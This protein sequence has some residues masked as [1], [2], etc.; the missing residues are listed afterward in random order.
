[1]KKFI[2]AL[3]VMALLVSCAADEKTR[4]RWATFNIRLDLPSDSLNSW[5]YRKDSVANYVKANGIDI[6]G[7]QEVLYNQLEDLVARL[8]EY[9]YVGVG[10]D[11]GGKKGEASPI[12][13]R[14]D[15]FEVLDSGTFW[16]SQYP[17][18]AGFIGWDGGYPRIA[19]WAKLREKAS[20]KTL[21][22][23]NT[24]FDDTGTEAQRNAALLIIDRI[25][26]LADGC[27]TVLSGD[28]NV[29]DQ[30][31]AYRTITQ[32]EFVLRDAHKI[33]K[34]TSGPAY[35]F[36]DFGQE[37]VAI[38]QKIDFIFVTPDIVVN[39]STVY[40]DHLYDPQRPETAWGYISDH[41]PVMAEIEF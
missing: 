15:R 3:A 35:T 2:L 16:L 12:F 25:K 17:D 33:A 37:P 29:D 19:T 11:D 7:M 26:V 20:G 21:L 5:A 22:A 40:Q 27:P 6:V 13:Y 18:S 30:S 9:A 41:N 31:E 24:H 10:R 4:V 39:S 14:T 32:N 36:H 34:V 8:P 28:L 1:M 23:M 38:R